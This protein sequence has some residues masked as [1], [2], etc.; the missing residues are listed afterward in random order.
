MKIAVFSFAISRAILII[1]RVNHRAPSPDRKRKARLLANLAEKYG[2]LTPM[3][4]AQ[5]GAKSDHKHHDDYNKPLDV[6]WL[7][8]RCHIGL[9]VSER[10]KEVEDVIMVLEKFL[11]ENPT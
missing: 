1:D 11:A 6:T 3:P 4:C 9:H 10:S 8:R 2:F 7:C 5:C